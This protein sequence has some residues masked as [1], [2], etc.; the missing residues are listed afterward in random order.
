MS[1]NSHSV[2]TSENNAMT[3]GNY[4]NTGQFE[5]GIRAA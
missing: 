5:Q 3:G 4:Y 2:M 1:V